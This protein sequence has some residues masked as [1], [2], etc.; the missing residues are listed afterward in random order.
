MLAGT[1]RA[2]L[3]RRVYHQRKS[4]R[5]SPRSKCLR[6]GQTGVPEV[7]EPEQHECNGV[8]HLQDE[9]IEYPWEAHRSERYCG[10]PPGCHPH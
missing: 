1:R 8:T 3:P 7:A 2:A 6:V 10:D 9:R 5:A 4:T